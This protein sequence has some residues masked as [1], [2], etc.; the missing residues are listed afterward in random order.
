MPDPSEI[1]AGLTQIANEAFAASIAW[2]AVVAASAA[3]LLLGARPRSRTAALA[4][5]LPLL[6]VSMFAFRYANPFN[7]AVFTLVA[8]GLAW[9]AIRGPRRAL[10]L[11]APWSFTLGSALIAFA[12]V[13]PHFLVDRP[14]VAY[15]VAAPL[16]T[17]P[18]PTLS[19]VTGA[20]LL[21]DELA[22]RAWRIVLGSTAAFYALFGMLRLGVAIDAVLLVGAIALLAREVLPV[23][24]TCWSRQSS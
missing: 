8:A 17:I 3:L 1:L 20:A 11:G 6:S 21:V 10:A 12:W 2:H 5:S 22:S 9:L 15:L 4:L 16:G 19:L 7:G 14:P 24:S 23:T 18:C 13:Y